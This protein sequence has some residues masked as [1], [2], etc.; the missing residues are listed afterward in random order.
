MPHF[1]SSLGWKPR[2]A[3]PIQ[4]ALPLTSRPTP[5][6][7]VS[8]SVTTMPPR[9]QGTSERAPRAVMMRSGSMRD[10]PNRAANASSASTAGR[11]KKTDSKLIGS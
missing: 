4:R 9:I 1:A 10:A 2:N 7:C 5:G 8:A 6:T 3:G 11:P